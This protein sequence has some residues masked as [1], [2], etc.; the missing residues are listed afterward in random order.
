MKSLRQVR[1]A[2]RRKPSRTLLVPRSNP[3]AERIPS[4]GDEDGAF[5]GQKDDIPQL[6]AFCRAVAG[7]S[8]SNLAF[9]R[10]G[11]AGDGDLR[12]GAERTDAAHY[13]GRFRSSGGC[14]PHEREGE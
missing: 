1:V 2:I 4:T 8:A 9:A 7:L 3:F 6:L 11:R 10:A 12:A 13:A 5:A 14:H